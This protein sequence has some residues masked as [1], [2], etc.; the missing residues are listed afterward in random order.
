MKSCNTAVLFLIFNRLETTKSVFSAIRRA[1]PPRLYIAAD[2]PR[3]DRCGEAAKVQEV[4]E[5]VKKNIDW[6]CDVKIRFRNQNLG[7]KYSVSDAISWFFE[8]EEQG[9]ILEDDCLPSD[10]FFGFCEELLVRYKDDP[11]VYLISGD[12]AGAEA[13][14]IHEDYGF[15]KYPMIWGWASW[16]RAWAEYDPEMRDWPVCRNNIIKSISEY[17]STRRFWKNTLDL[18]F[19]KKIDTWDYQFCYLLFKKKGKCIV[20]RVNLISNIGFGA[21]ATHTRDP[22][23]LAANRE[24]GEIELPLTSSPSFETEVKLN[25]YYDENDFHMDAFASRIFTRLLRAFS[26]FKKYGF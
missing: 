4:R 2:G 16:R 19:H 14:N 26:K 18:T 12:A 1:Q 25:K 13:C 24:I 22:S 20:P 7:C 17:R 10:S 23:D 9:I 21:D 15:C 11:E 5:Y 6:K 3:Y 8:Q